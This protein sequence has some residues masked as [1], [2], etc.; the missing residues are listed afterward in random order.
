MTSFFASLVPTPPQNGKAERSL[1]TINDT[2]R[3][4]LVQSS[5]TSKFWAEAL[6]TTTFLL[7]IH[8]SKTNP[9]ITPYYSLFLCHP[10]TPRFVFSAVFAF[11]MPMLPLKTNFLHDLSHVSFLVFSPNKKVTVVLIYTLDGYMCLFNLDAI[12]RSSYAYH[13][14]FWIWLWS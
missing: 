12:H 8:P 1:C 14:Y 3:T 7:N 10:I 4:L 13:I 2:V 9:N 6:H 5:I 11:Q